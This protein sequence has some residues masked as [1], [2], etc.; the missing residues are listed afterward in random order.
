MSNGWTDYLTA[1]YWK[2]SL[3]NKAKTSTTH[4]FQGLCPF[5]VAMLFLFIHF[6][7]VFPFARVDNHQEESLSE[8]ISAA[9]MQHRKTLHFSYKSQ[10]IPCNCKS[11][12]CCCLVL[13]FSY[14]SSCSFL[15]MLRAVYL[16]PSLFWYK[17][18]PA[19][20]DPAG[21]TSSFSAV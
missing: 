7:C 18:A 3:G 19:T 6:V 14:S 20:N 15:Q 21:T 12:S 2:A 11:S 1:G 5:Q 13:H 16:T 9:A 4:I 10:L 17:P 8:K